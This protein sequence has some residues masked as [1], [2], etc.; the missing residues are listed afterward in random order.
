MFTRHA[1]AHRVTTLRVDVPVDDLSIPCVPT[2]VGSFD[3]QGGWNSKSNWGGMH[4]ALGIGGIM[5]VINQDTIRFVLDKL[6]VR[7]PTWAREFMD[8]V[9]GFDQWPQHVQAAVQAAEREA[10]E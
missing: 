8:R 6:N 3:R 1:H 2:T 10:L 9:E 7:G 5:P 4:D